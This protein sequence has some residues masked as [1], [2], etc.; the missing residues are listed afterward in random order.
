MLKIKRK[1][2]FLALTLYT[3][4]FKQVRWS[5]SAIKIVIKSLIFLFYVYFDCCTQGRSNN[6][7]VEYH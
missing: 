6:V 3:G 1:L 7:L 5:V 4:P 2:S